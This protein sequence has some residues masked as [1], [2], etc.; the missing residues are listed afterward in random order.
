VR[1]CAKGAT[2]MMRR[3]FTAWLVLGMLLSLGCRS[4]KPEESPAT[5]AAAPVSNSPVS[6]N[7]DDYP[8]FPNPDAGAGPA[9]PADQGGNGVTGQGWETNTSFDL[10]GDPRAVKGGALRDYM[11]N[12]PGTWRMGGPEW[13]T[14][15]NYEVNSLVYETLLNLHPTTL[16]WIPSIASH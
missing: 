6:F 11:P 15:T 7:K 1:Q 2:E 13:N 10:I 8:V 3:I 12:F 9:G 5:G 4:S 16:E 14:E